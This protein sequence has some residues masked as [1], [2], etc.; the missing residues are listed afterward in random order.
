MS[1]W[2]LTEGKW[3]AFTVYLSTSRMC[4]EGQIVQESLHSIRVKVVPSGVFSQL[5]VQDIVHRVQQRLGE[6]IQVHV[7]QVAEI[8]STK[9]GK[10]SGGCF[11]AKDIQK[12][13]TAI[14]SRYTHPSHSQ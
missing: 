4:S 14:S 7:E 10:V 5:D 11:L 8:S 2:D 3:S 13:M 9:A 12:S 1:S 6:G